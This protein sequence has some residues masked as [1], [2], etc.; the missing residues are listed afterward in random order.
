MSDPA[1]EPTTARIGGGHKARLIALGVLGSLAAVVWVG[2]AGRPAPVPQL[3]AVDPTPRLTP[4][5]ASP[6]TAV[7][8]EAATPPPNP[9]AEPSSQPSGYV[10]NGVVGTTTFNVPMVQ[11][12]SGALSAQYRVPSPPQGSS[13]AFEITPLRGPDDAPLVNLGAWVVSLDR[14]AG[15]VRGGT[16]GYHATVDPR[17]TQL[18][19]P[20][21]IRR[22]FGVHVSV[23][24]AQDH[25]AVI[26][27]AVNVAPRREP[28]GD[29]G[30]VGCRA[31]A[32]CLPSR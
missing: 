19:A 3:A 9:R 17:P 12:P 31:Y 18:Q 26:D 32:T 11:G 8:T 25:I 30:I 24:L 29:D 22:G 21:P 10:I 6:P 20:L 14:L 5:T 15:D 13:L 23:Q 4:P 7:P 28:I 2:F 16:Q 1:P 27:F